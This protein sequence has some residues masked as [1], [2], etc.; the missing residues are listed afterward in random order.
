[1]PFVALYLL[2]DDD[3][4]VVVTAGPRKDNFDGAV[5]FAVD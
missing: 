4:E 1:M 3:D 5:E 2:F